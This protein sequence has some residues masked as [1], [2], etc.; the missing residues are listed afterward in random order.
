MPVLPVRPFLPFRKSAAPD[1]GSAGRSLAPTQPLYAIGDIHGSSALVEPLLARID[2]DIVEAGHADPHLVFLG[3]YVDRGDG[4][5]S[6]LE[7][8]RALQADLPGSVTCLMG[9]HERMMLDFLDDPAG[10]GARWLANGGLQTLASFGV[11]GIGARPSLEDMSDAAEALHAALPA[12]LEAWLRAL[13]LWW[14]SG[15]VVC[16]HAAMNP[17]KPPEAQDNR[18][19]LWGHRRFFE[20]PREDGLW[21]VHGHTITREPT[22]AGGRIAVDTGAYHSGRLTAAAITEGGCRFL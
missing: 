13:P 2:A 21:V 3:D 14:Q 10:R 8:L 16:V 17:E 15:N 22:V 20:I 1:A 19:L 9:N 18:A 12:G 5:A 7:H 6:V 11:G 4:S